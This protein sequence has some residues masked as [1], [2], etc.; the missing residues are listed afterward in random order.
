[1][2]IVMTTVSSSEEGE[3]LAELIVNERLAACVQIL[4]QMTSVY[5]WEGKVQRESEYLLLAKTTSE[6][7][8]QLEAFILANHTYETPE[9]VAIYAE[10][11]SAPYAKW[12]TDALT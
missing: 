11:V 12:L 2:L 7:Y 4:P 1:M 8:A 3:N 10:K 5:I 6:K 9:V